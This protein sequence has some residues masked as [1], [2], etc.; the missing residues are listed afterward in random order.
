MDLNGFLSLGIPSS[1]IQKVFQVGSSAK[2]GLNIPFSKPITSRHSI[3]LEELFQSVAVSDKS[4]NIHVQ[5]T[6]QCWQRPVCWIIRA[7]LP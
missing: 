1:N 4:H 6:Q 3:S 7:G 5:L 2:E